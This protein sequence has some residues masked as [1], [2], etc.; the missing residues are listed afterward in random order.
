MSLDFKISSGRGS[1]RKTKKRVL[2]ETLILQSELQRKKTSTS[3]VGFSNKGL[4]ASWA[5]SVKVSTSSKIII[6]GLSV[7]PKSPDPADSVK[8]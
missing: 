1:K 2:K 5:G 6:F 4:R 7:Y 3:D 8:G